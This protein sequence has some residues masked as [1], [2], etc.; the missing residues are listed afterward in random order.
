VKL[1]FSRPERLRQVDLALLVAVAAIGVR[2][3]LPGLNRSLWLDE[4][5]IAM[6]LRDRDL[7]QLAGALS[8]EQSAPLGWLWIERIALVVYGPAEW[9]LRLQPFVFGAGTIV[10]A[11]WFGRRWLSPLASAALVALFGFNYAALVYTSELKHYSS[12][13]FWGLALI[14]LARWVL[15]DRDSFKRHLAWWGAAIA[16][17]W[18]S[19]GGILVTPGIAL[20][21]VLSTRPWRAWVK[22]AKF[23]APGLVWVASFAAH[24][25]LSLRPA[26][27]NQYLQDFW[28]GLGYPPAGA[29]LFGSVQW[30]AGQLKYIL[31]TT[32]YLDIRL[33]PA[34]LAK[35]LFVIFSLLTIAGLAVALKRSPAFGLV[36]CA[37]LITGVVLA[38]LRVIPLF[39]RLSLWL[40]PAIFVAVAHA[41]EYRPAKVRW[42]ISVVFL[43]MLVP[44]TNSVIRV[45]TPMDV[46]DRAAIAWLRQRHQPGDLTIFVGSSERAASWYDNG[47]RLSPAR[48]AVSQPG[49]CA[50]AELRDAVQGYRRVLAYAGSRFAPYYH[51]YQV[52]EDQLKTLGTIREQ[53]RF[54]SDGITYVVELSATPPPV[55][56]GDGECLKVY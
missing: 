33:E 30:F 47:N 3:F 27:K 5:L 52:M 20:V 36:L 31:H 22:L 32:I 19:M 42:V 45:A 41:L 55:M 8:H 4:E 9:A 10:V 24:Y 39:G 12:D 28:A 34:L 29:G 26:T 2:A 14:A 50:S 48:T 6:N 13:M 15:D 44:F 1:S 16:G 53:Q 46:D 43:A 17:S 40:I 7:A 18:L 38:Q 11:W 25:L 35:S 51:S 37:P 23:A 49:G 21:L 54:G 56:A